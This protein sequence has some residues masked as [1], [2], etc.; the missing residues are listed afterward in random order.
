MMNQRIIANVGLGIAFL[1]GGFP[2]RV[3]AGTPAD[4]VCYCEI[5]ENPSGNPKYWANPENALTRDETNPG[6]SL[7]NWND[8]KGPEDNPGQDPLP[9]SLTGGYDLNQGNPPGLV[10]GFSTA[11]FNGP[12]N[13][14]RILGNGFTIEGSDY[15]WSEP[16]YIEVAMETTIEGKTGATADGWEDEVFYL[17]RPSNYDDVGD[18]RLGPL[19]GIYVYGDDPGGGV[20]DQG[21]PLQ[22][23]YYA[24]S[25]GEDLIAAGGSQ[26]DLYGY[27]DWNPA[28]DEV[29]I[30][31]AIRPD[32]T[33]QSL[34]NIAYV[35][36]RT[37][38]NDD[39]GVFGSMSTDICYIENIS[40]PE[41]TM[42]TLLAVGGLLLRKRRYHV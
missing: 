31:D 30:S 35:R 18:P 7:G 2:P 3:S 6:I 32:G 25:W 4:V 13:D 22:V 21:N 27:A 39:A 5:G 23:Q 9:L 8:Y 36:I 28:G 41:P 26:L 10:V 37:V 15:Y 19:T 20:D 33:P 11:V 29:D 12:G 34:T 24:D 42:L 16:G 17:I 14:I 38:S 1:L 40:T